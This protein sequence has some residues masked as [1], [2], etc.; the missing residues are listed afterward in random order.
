MKRNI[1]KKVSLSLGLIFAVAGFVTTVT[2]SS[3]SAKKMRY[4]L[5]QETLGIIKLKPANNRS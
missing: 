3:A 5:T 2:I 4:L 1:L